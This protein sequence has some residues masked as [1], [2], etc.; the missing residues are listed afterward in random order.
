MLRTDRVPLVAAAAILVAATLAAQTGPPPD[1]MVKENT[2]V[3][4]GNHT[5]VIPDG[6]VPLVPNVGIVVGRRATLVIDPGLGRENG[7]RVLREVARVSRNG[8]LYVASTHFHP[9]HT[10]GYVAFPPGAK[11]VNSKTQEAEFEESGMKMIQLFAGRSPR[12]AELL[13]DAARRP[14]DITFDREDTVDLGGVQV[15]CL[16]VGP[17][18]TRGD[19]GFF[20]EGDGVLF[21]GDVVMNESFLAAGGATSMKAWLAAFDTFEGLKPRTIV[22]AHGAVGPGSIIAANRAIMQAV[23]AR[24]LA[25]KAEGRSADEAATI[26]QEEFQAKHPAWPRANGL[27]AAARAAYNEG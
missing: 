23:R 8:E 10:T 21:A 1:P 17:T 26:V 15:R 22:P 5:Y 2:I 9:E 14:A 25:L 13:K 18:H 4:L 11:Y 19:T 3:K 27:A 7:E 20:V 24:A 16:L 12:T 6:N